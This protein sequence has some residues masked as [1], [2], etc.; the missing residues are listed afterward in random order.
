MIFVSL[1]GERRGNNRAANILRYLND[2][3]MFITSDFD[4]SR[5]QYKTPEELSGAFNIHVPSYRKNLSLDRVYSHIVFA[6]KL[7]KKL[8]SLQEVPT[9]I[10][11]SMP[12]ST[13][14]YVC[15]KFCKKHNVKFV[16]DVI[17]L[18]PD[19]LIPIMGR[20]GAR[21][22]KFLIWPWQF[23]TIQTYK[24]ADVILG[25]SRQYAH[26]A[27]CY[28]HR[29]SVYPLYLG[30]DKKKVSELITES[31]LILYKPDD[32]IWIGYGGNL[33][34][35]YDFET[36]IKGVSAL[37]GKYRYKLFLIG[38]GICR[39]EIERLINL[40][41]ANAEITGFLEY[42]DL[43]KYLFF[44]DIAVN[45][46]RDNTK[47]VHSYKFNDYVATNCFILNSL[48]GETADMVDQYKIGLNFDFGDNSFD[49]V[50]LRCM[51]NWSDYKEWKINSEQ[52]VN[53]LL[54][55]EVIY[56]RIRS[57][58]YNE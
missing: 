6:Y 46:F 1:F 44:C 22:V 2:D 58:L 11:C 16:I 49:K 34:V 25:E 14:A 47:V 15:G 9:T 54:D 35:S 8:N 3:V 37:N 7:R 42:G 30:V 57:I 48:P 45:I 55:K 41:S 17:D 36:L 19:S 18:W 21:F 56:S 26:E 39:M 28:N 51:K 32:E 27:A 50:L 31:K 38:D 43:L 53:D 40:Y 23:V 4:H 29:A 52:L 13:A 10:Y 20:I 5:K 24:M 33:G 12:T